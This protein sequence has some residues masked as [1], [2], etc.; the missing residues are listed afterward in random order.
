MWFLEYWKVVEALV[1]SFLVYVILL[2]MLF[3]NPS[4]LIDFTKEGKAMKLVHHMLFPK[5]RNLSFVVALF[6]PW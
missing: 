3:T 6:N 2:N 4:M 1:R 5:I